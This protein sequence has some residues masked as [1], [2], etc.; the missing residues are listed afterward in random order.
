MIR[1]AVASNGLPWLASWY[2]SSSEIELRLART[3]QSGGPEFVDCE[4]VVPNGAV[5]LCC[6]SH[7]ARGCVQSWRYGAP[8]GYNANWACVSLS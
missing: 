5:T 7:S 4:R 8:G 3:P 2:R 1:A 6:C